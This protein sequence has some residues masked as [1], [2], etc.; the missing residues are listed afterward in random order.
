M[1]RENQHATAYLISRGADIEALDTYGY[2]P[3]HRM[4]SNNL[5]VGAQALLDAGADP[6][7]AHTQ[8][9]EGPMEVAMQSRAADVLRVLKNHAKEYNSKRRV[10]MV[11]SIRILSAG[12]PSSDGTF[13]FSVLEGEY[14]HVDG[15]V[16][17]PDGFAAV[18]EQQGW[19]TGEMWRRL[20][21]GEDLRW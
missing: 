15:Q 1:S 11:A 20:N 12:G 6:H 21:G 4:A 17:I 16:T 3:L 2:T 19:N 5:A 13:D 10:N 18:C 9:T 14:R 8:A 7:S